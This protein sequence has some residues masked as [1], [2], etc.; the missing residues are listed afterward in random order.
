ME[1]RKIGSKK[2]QVNTLTASILAVTL[3][4]IVFVF[5]LTVIDNLQGTQTT[6][7]LVYNETGDAVTAYAGFN[8]YWGLVVLAVII[9]VVFGLIF[10]AFGRPARR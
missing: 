9:G 6:D 7:S 3:A 10:L 1:M 4:I 2:G 5:G 8:D